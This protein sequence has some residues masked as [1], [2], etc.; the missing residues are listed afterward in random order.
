MTTLRNVRLT[1]RFLSGHM[2]AGIE[3]TSEIA[4]CS[5]CTVRDFHALVGSVRNGVEFLRVEEF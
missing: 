1:V 3:H 2:L 5:P 4:N